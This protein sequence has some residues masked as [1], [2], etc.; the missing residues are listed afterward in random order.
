M[1]PLFADLAAAPDARFIYESIDAANSILSILNSFIDPVVGLKYMPLKYSLFVIYAAVFLFKVR[2][3]QRQFASPGANTNNLK[4]LECRCH[5][6]RRH[7]RCQTRHPRHDIAASKDVAQHP[8]H[9]TPVCKV[10]PSTLAKTVGK[11]NSKERQQYRAAAPA[12][13]T[14][15]PVSARRP[16]RFRG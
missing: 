12:V 15:K 1:G 14:S 2:H 16:A 6:Q 3:L 7:C 5:Q 11:T 8:E 9:W 13:H 4:G 10:S